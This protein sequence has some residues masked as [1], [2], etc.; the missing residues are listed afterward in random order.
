MRF[1]PFLTVE[2]GIYFMNN[3]LDEAL[4]DPAQ[5]CFLNQQAL[6]S[7]LRR[8][9]W[10]GSLGPSEG[11]EAGGGEWGEAGGLNGGG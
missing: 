3:L 9:V 2:P 1:L 10:G 6:A 4:A 5:S 11:W 8:G 7:V